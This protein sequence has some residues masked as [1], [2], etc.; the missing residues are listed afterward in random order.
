M[1][2][3]CDDTESLIQ[4]FKDT[5][6]RLNQL[7]PVNCAEKKHYI[8]ELFLENIYIIGATTDQ[9]STINL[10][11][12]ELNLNCILPFLEDYAFWGALTV[13]YDSSHYHL[14][15]RSG[16]QFLIDHINND[17]VNIL[18]ESENLKEYTDRLCICIANPHIGW[19][20]RIY[21]E[22]EYI[23]PPNIPTS[24]VWWK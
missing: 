9:L 10:H 18:K 12:I 23:R 8:I 16:L 11:D 6:N 2:T 13:D 5:V 3:K 19:D 24:H 15:L 4:I 20:S 21:S 1:A 14:I 7:Q 17:S 22:K